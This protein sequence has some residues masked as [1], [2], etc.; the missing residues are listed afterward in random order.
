M[1]IGELVRSAAAMAPSSSAPGDA[2]GSPSL[3]QLSSA[4]RALLRIVCWV[5]WADGDFAEEERE[6]LEKLVF[7]LLPP[8]VGV[9]EAEDAYRALAA[10]QLQTVDVEALV[11]ELHGSDERQ[12][13]VKLAVQMLAVNQRPGDAAPVNP[14]EKQAY[15]RLLEALN[16]PDGEVAEA[17]W[18]ARRE[19]EQKRSLLEVIGMALAGWGAWPAMDVEG[20]SLPP[21]YWL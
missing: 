20:G 21:G 13:A 6:L 12:L 8:D 4:Q 18:A 9:A 7:R 11:A 15:R 1:R 2:A 16:L 17:E 19:L 5:A 3:Q 14:A 10:E